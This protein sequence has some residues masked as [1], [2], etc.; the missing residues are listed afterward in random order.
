M[1]ASKRHRKNI[2]KAQPDAI[3]LE[4]AVDRLKSFQMTKFDETVEVAIRTGI[5]PKQ[6]SQAVRGA[7]SLPHG[8][9]KQVRVIA[10]CEGADAEKAKEAGA[11]EAG[12]EELAKKVEGGWLDFDDQIERVD[13]DDARNHAFPLPYP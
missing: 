12:G 9:G 2:E 1:K 5:D 11:I 6:T 7:Y 8:I 10:F 4:Q 3:P 13:G